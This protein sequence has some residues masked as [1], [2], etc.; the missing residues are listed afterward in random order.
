MILPFKKSIF[1]EQLYRK[2]LYKCKMK[3]FSRH[4]ISIDA[5]TWCLNVS[6]TASLSLSIYLSIY[7][8]IYIYFRF[9]PT[10]VKG[11]PKTLLSLATILR[12][13]GGRYPSSWIAR[14]TWSV[15]FD[16]YTHTHTHT[17]I[18][19]YIDKS[20]GSNIYIYIYIN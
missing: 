5:L 6:P 3:A 12:C 10:I 20:F 15:T 9:C 16:I 17:H 1:K 7:I 13:W 18:Y 14:L 19:I 11:E 4:K 8:Y 2:C